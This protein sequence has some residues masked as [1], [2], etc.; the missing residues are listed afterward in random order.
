MDQ[1][2]ATRGERAVPSAADS[3]HQAI[4]VDSPVFTEKFGDAKAGSTEALGELLENCRNYLLLIAN[5]AMKQGLQAKVGASDLVQETFIEAQRIF[6]R[7]EGKS[8]EELLQW[9]RKI[10]EHKVGNTLK[11]YYSAASRDVNKELDFQQL[12]DN[13]LLTGVVAGNAAGESP[14]GILINQ[15]NQQRYQQIL[16]SLSV[17]YQEVI[18]LRVDEDLAFEEIGRRMERSAEAA[19]KLYARAVVRLQNLLGPFYGSVPETD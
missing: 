19:R 16:S 13:V 8:E 17:E 2:P 12:S 10:L 14:S 11:R 3:R 1:S 5:V 4:P 7:F 6:G 9:L 18:R 15:E